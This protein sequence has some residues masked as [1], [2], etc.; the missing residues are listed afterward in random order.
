MHVL[1]R[2]RARF[3]PTTLQGRLM[4]MVAVLVGIQVAVSWALLSD[5]VYDLLREQMG[6]RALQTAQTVAE[7]PAIRNALLIKDPSGVIQTIADTVRLKVGA[8]F[9]VV[10]DATGK[11][12]SH[13]VRDRIGKQ[14]VGG[15]T[16]PALLEGKSYV[17]E[18]V[19][20][21]GRSIRGM[22]PIFDDSGAIIGFV[23]V[24]YLTE[25]VGRIVR[26]NMG[27]PLLVIGVLLSIG[28]TGA[29]WI[30]HRVKRLTLGLEPA[31][32]TTL[33]LERGAIL[34][35]IR[36]GV[37]AVDEGGGIAMA[38]KA[39]LRHAGLD[40]EQPAGG[41]P[42]ADILPGL[43]VW[44][45]LHR[46][47]AVHDRDFSMAGR[48]FVGNVVPVLHEGRVQGA[49]A[50]FRPTDELDSLARELSR[51]QEYTELL[52]VQSHEYSNKLHTIAGLL[53]LGAHQEALDLVARESSG[54]QE[55]IR[56]VQKAIAQPVIAAIVMGKYAR[57]GEL[58]IAFAV[59]RHSSLGQVPDWINQEKIVTILGNLLDNAFES[60]LDKPEG[61]RRAAL[62]FTDLGNELLFEVEDAGPGV[63]VDRTEAI[64]ERGV[65][66]KGSEHRGVGLHLVRQCIA[67]LGGQVTV[68]DSDLGGALFTVAIPKHRPASGPRQGGN[69]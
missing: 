19:G 33:Y 58:R 10:G 55:M 26:D 11:R 53:Q 48:E 36:E 56:F 49:V 23:S 63:P 66:G 51:V 35:S 40:P 17:S 25:N 15:D 6:R 68:S 27:M 20:T 7:I 54:Y 52:R 28:L 38:N 13:P 37:A 14:F 4:L 18:A 9:V 16:G 67:D 42:V 2:L 29:A 60:V 43:D 69:A 24:G 31:E 62:S 12:Y 57:A 5:L 59:D 22:V 61:E 46:G 45:V 34:D 41:R 1:A 39:A 3:G 47:E 44:P 50:T 8:H 32:I 65:S 64:F 30:A 21:L